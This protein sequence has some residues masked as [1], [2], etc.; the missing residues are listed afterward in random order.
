MIQKLWDGMTRGKLSSSASIQEFKSYILTN[1]I[2]VLI[3]ISNGLLVLAHMLLM[4]L[5]YR[6]FSGT[7]VT[8]CSL[9]IYILCLRL[10]HLEKANLCK[11]I[12]LLAVNTHIAALIFVY[13]TLSG[14][15]FLFFCAF[16]LPLILSTHRNL[17]KIIFSMSL[18]STLFICGYVYYLDAA[19]RPLVFLPTVARFGYFVN[20]LFSFFL[21]G[22]CVLYFFR[23]THKAEDNLERERKRSDD[24]LLNILPKSIA[25][26]LKQKE[27]LIADQFDNVTVLFAD[28]VGFTD[29]SLTL[30]PAELVYVLNGLFT[31]F[32]Q[33]TGK[34]DLE[35]IKTIGDA[36]MV[37]SGVPTPVENHAARIA[38]MS[39]D[40]LEAVQ[41]WAGQLGFE[42]QIRIGIHSGS[43][44]A[45][46]IGKR[47]FI[48]DLWGDAVNTASRMESHGVPG[49]IQISS[50]TYELLKGNYDIKFRNR[51]QV[52]GRGRMR[53]YFLEGRKAAVV[54]AV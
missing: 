46:V 48:Y 53:T 34:H 28:I 3:I 24:L 21:L 15:Q 54:A 26:R 5:G 13:G 38:E 37:V 32:D 40:M 8:A 49:R 12:F 41:D 52:K 1:Q 50:D 2:L 11:F 31:K 16:V 42:L 45:G 47:K 36:Y 22:M 51:I 10:S 25:E 17:T 29:L 20:A 33:L 19:A 4:L 14:V 43:I 30:K 9:G 27:D 35:K 44:V 23:A 6:V 18:S 39:L 7:L